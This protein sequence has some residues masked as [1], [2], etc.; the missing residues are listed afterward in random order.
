MT[1]TL[2]AR[3]LRQAYRQNARKFHPDVNPS[4]DAKEKFQGINEAYSI[5]S[6]PEQRQRYDQFGMAGV[7]GAAGGA[8]NMQV[9]STPER[10]RRRC[11]RRGVPHSCVAGRRHVMTP[12]DGPAV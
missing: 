8:P 1:P 12:Q 9:W 5:L 3:S 11:R 10:C 4:E 6:D 7:K 2:T